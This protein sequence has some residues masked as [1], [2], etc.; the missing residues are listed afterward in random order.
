[1][2]IFPLLT[3]EGLPSPRVETVAAEAGRAGLDVS[4][5][6]VPYEFQRGGNRMMRMR[7]ATEGRLPEVGG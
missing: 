5:E 7:R 1:V 3:L 6:A 4:I 2:R